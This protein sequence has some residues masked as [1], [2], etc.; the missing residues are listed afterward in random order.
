MI[1]N[2]GVRF[3][4]LALYI[5]EE[6]GLSFFGRGYSKLPR[7]D[8]LVCGKDPKRYPKV[9]LE[10]KADTLIGDIQ[11]FILSASDIDVE[12]R[13]A[14]GIK[15]TRDIMVGQAHALTV[16]DA[17]NTEN[18]S[19]AINSALSIADKSSSYSDLDWMQRILTSAAYKITNH[20]EIVVMAETLVEVYRKRPEL[21]AN[22]IKSTI[23]IFCK[24]EV[25]YRKV[26]EVLLRSEAP[27]IKEL[28][29]SLQ[30]P[31]TS[32]PE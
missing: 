13:N 16:P 18:L 10:I 20:E 26:S 31:G 1:L 30:N 25:A 17:A 5:R 22:F 2:G 4:D 23:D 7:G 19:A 24:D 28:A 9:S 8:T 12:F 29:L 6:F 11:E 3:K 21:T 27:E 15:L 32:K 14:D